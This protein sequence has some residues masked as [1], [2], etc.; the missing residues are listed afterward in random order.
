MKI[1][2]GRG[3]KRARDLQREKRTKS[4]LAKGKVV[5]NVPWEE[6]K[7][8]NGQSF[9]ARERRGSKWFQAGKD[10]E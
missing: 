6:R 3:G 7:K 1:T 10:V 4:Q 8:V 5:Y 9:F 2:V